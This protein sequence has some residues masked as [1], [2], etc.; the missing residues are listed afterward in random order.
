MAEWC[1]HDSWFRIVFRTSQCIRYQFLCGRAW[2]EPFCSCCTH[3]FCATYLEMCWLL[4]MLLHEENKEALQPASQFGFGT[5]RSVR[6]VSNGVLA[7]NNSWDSDEAL[8]CTQSQV[9]GFHTHFRSTKHWL[10]SFF[11]FQ[12]FFFVITFE[13]VQS[14]QK[15]SNYV[16]ANMLIFSKYNISHVCYL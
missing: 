15:L 9:L 10:M 14:D 1:S 6:G 4:S 7:R 8:K 16:N 5:R 3:W 2:C 13:T 11:L 12:P